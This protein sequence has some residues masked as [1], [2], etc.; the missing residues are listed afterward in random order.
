M[1]IIIYTSYVYKQYIILFHVSQSTNRCYQYDSVKNNCTHFKTFLHTQTTTKIS[2][3]ERLGF[4]LRL[5]SE[6]LNCIL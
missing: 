3:L 4:S 6:I 1:A 2:P 5:S